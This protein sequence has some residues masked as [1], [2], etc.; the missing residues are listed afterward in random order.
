MKFTHL[1]PILLLGM[2]CSGCPDSEEPSAPTPDEGS[3]ADDPQGEPSQEAGDEPEPEASAEELPATSETHDAVEESAP[4][5]LLVVMRAIGY[6]DAQPSDLAEF[7]PVPPGATGEA[8]NFGDGEREVSVALLRY[9]NPRYAR[10]H[11]TDVQERR[12]VLPATGEAVISDGRFVIHIMATNRE[13]AD[14][15]ASALASEL[16]WS[17]DED[18]E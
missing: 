7:V 9:P 12:L 8:G 13:T 15:V 3:G 11:V 18:S 10:P 2:L 4:P 16:D 17:V 6:A 14:A 5:E 1:A